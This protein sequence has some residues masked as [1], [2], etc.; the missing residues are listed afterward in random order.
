[1]NSTEKQYSIFKA[2]LLS[3]FS[4]D[5]YSDTALKAKGLGFLYLFVLIFVC[6]TLSTASGC[7]HFYMNIESK[8]L[9]DIVQRLPAMEIKRGKL[10]IDKE[11]PYKL[12]FENILSK[13]KRVIVFDT[14][15]QK[16]T[17]EDADVLFTQDGIKFQGDSEAIPWTSATFGNDFSLNSANFK[18]LLGSIA[19]WLFVIGVVL[20]P[21]SWLGHALLAAIYGLAGLAMDRK[22][23]GY[24]T[25]VRMAIVALTPSIVLSTIFHVLYCMPE[26][27]GLITVPVTLGYLFFGYSSIADSGSANQ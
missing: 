6:Q 9:N 17:E 7:V 18:G 16:S 2:P 22:K 12:Q 25:A 24:K 14:S 13:E 27:W 11:S 21:L 8:E 1:M 3:F 20:S 10:S 4:K 26:L 23:L 15:G 19:V 5:F